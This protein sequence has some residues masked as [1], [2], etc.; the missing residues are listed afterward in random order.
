[1]YRNHP[2]VRVPNI[3]NGKFQKPTVLKILRFSIAH[4]PPTCVKLTDV[5]RPHVY[6]I[7]ALDLAHPLVIQWASQSLVLELECG[8][9]VTSILTADKGGYAFICII[10]REASIK[11][12]LWIKSLKGLSSILNQK[13]GDV[14][15]ATLHG[16]N[17]S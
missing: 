14:K 11:Y 6:C 1:L 16:K 15:F 4:H 17:K 7:F 3:L 8:S 5:K 9:V 10:Q 12:F 13:E 2:I